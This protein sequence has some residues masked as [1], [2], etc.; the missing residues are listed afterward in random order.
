MAELLDETGF[1]GSHARL[2]QRISMIEESDH[3]LQPF[4]F[5]APEF[6]YFQ[7]QV[8]FFRVACLLLKFCEC[9]GGSPCCLSSPLQS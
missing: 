2:S 7:A 1:S 3:Y 5:R 4:T 6:F 8:A 9:F